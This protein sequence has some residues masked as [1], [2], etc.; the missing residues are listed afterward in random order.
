MEIGTIIFSKLTKN[1][2]ENEIRELINFQFEEIKRSIKFNPQALKGILFGPNCP[3]SDKN[4]IIGKL[5]QQKKYKDFELIETIIDLIDQKIKVKE[6][7][8]DL[9]EKINR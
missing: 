2:Y 6:H 3:E 9:N 7:K 1:K 8:L 4:K 5:N